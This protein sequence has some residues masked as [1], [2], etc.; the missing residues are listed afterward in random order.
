[1][2]LSQPCANSRTSHT[3]H[4][5]ICDFAMPRKQSRPVKVV[6]LVSD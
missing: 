1:M 5:A 4:D 2:A 3:P 6:A